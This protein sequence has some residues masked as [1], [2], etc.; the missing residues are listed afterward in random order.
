MNICRRRLSQSVPASR[1]QFEIGS[2][3]EFCFFDFMRRFLKKLVPALFLLIGT[4][5]FAQYRIATVDLG[6]VFTN[7]WKT[8]QAQTTIDDRRADI[9]KTGKDMLATFNKSKDDYQ[10]MLDSVNDPAVSSEERDRRKKAAE[11]KLKD[12]RDQQDA[13]QQFDRGS[14]TSLDEQLK[15]T[16]DNIVTDI[17]TAVS[18]KA[19]ADGYTMVI[20]TAAQSINQTPVIL[21]SVPGEND[22]T[23]AVIKQI[24]MGAPATMPKTD[25]KPDSKGEGK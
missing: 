24:N 20:D 19:K 17:R 11:D 13:L 2:A 7:Y 14:T 23:D 16:R 4:S 18:A 15:R 5:A 21:Y 22:I 8:K 3:R 9:E 6:R 10:K 25:D 12:L 1:R